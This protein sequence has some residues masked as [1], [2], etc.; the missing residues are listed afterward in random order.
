MFA[1]WNHVLAPVRSIRARVV[2]AGSAVL[3]ISI[4]LI[5]IAVRWADASRTATDA[6]VPLRPL[7]APEA[8]A[9]LQHSSVLGS[10]TGHTAIVELDDENVR[11]ASRMY[12]VPVASPH[13]DSKDS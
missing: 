13:G 11:V 5:F 1:P 3:S 10:Q 2:I 8:A 9:L 4:V 7:T 12:L 6:Y